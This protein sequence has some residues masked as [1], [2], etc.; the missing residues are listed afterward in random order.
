MPH[1]PASS[2]VEACSAEP[3]SGSVLWELS[4]V[5]ISQAETCRL[6]KNLRGCGCLPAGLKALISLFLGRDRVPPLFPGATAGHFSTLEPCSRAAVQLSHTTPALVYP[7]PPAEIGFM[8]T[9]VPW[10]RHTLLLDTKSQH[11]FINTC[12]LLGSRG[13]QRAEGAPEVSRGQG[14]VEL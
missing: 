8:A 3:Q 6:G 1:F 9:Q 11:P 7:P 4:L 12:H 13:Y 2:H 5:G 14:W 10:C